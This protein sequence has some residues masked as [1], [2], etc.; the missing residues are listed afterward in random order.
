[1]FA[2]TSIYAGLLA[3]FFVGLSYSVTVRR[4]TKGISLGD[5]D[6][7][8]MRALTR[9]QGNCA[10]YAPLGILLLALSEA[11]GAPAIALHL[12]GIALLAGRLL[13]ARALLGPRM[14][15]PFRVS[16]MV[17]TFSALLLMGLGLL[18]HALF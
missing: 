2:V 18:F 7:S 13:H 12:L 15:L 16:G 3:I 14:S 17:L 10:E 11:Q 5:G 9:A 4:R 1:M 6:D 8:R